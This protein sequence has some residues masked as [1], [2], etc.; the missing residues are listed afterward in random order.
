MAFD[1]ISLVMFVI[2][3]LLGFV[4]TI[5]GLMDLIMAIERKKTPWLGFIGSTLAAVVWMSF[6]LVWVAGATMEIFVSFG[7]LYF[8]L[9]LSSTVFAVASVALI[10]RNS[11]KPEESAPLEIRERN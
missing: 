3:F 1:P 7:Y 5:L 10:F 9:M 2:V 11:V 8:A 6:A 4:F